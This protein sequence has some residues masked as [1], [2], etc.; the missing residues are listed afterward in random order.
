MS[1]EIRTPLNAIIGMTSLLLGTDLSPERQE[2]VE[3]IRQSSDQL[4]SLVSMQARHI[5]TYT[6]AGGLP[7]ACNGHG[8]GLKRPSFRPRSLAIAGSKYRLYTRARSLLVVMQISDIL[9]FSKIEAGT[10]ELESAPF[11]VQQCMEEAADLVAAKAAGKELELATY[12]HSSVPRTVQG[13]ISRL[14]QVLVRT[15]LQLVP[16]TRITSIA[17]QS[18]VSKDESAAW[19]DNN[20]FQC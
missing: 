3:T 9:D 13:D 1:H 2:C 5:T 16:V 20:N 10:L 14:R 8:H 4:L 7:F 17:D 15:R 19:N 18:L 6:A 11:S 12:T